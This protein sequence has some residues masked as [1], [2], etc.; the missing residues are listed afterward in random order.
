MNAVLV[1]QSL[2]NLI[3]GLNLADTG[4]DL[5]LIDRDH[6]SSSVDS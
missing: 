1:G 3:L 6:H 5:T 4:L 2:P